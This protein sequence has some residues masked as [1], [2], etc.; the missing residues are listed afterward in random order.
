M[1]Y[2]LDTG[3]IIAYASYIEIVPNEEIPRWYF[4]SQCEKAHSFF[5]NNKTNILSSLVES[6]VD[7]VIN[8]RKS[9]VSI[10]MSK[11]QSKRVNPLHKKNL[12]PKDFDWI[13]E[14]FNIFRRRRWDPYI[15]SYS[16]GD[17]LAGLENRVDYLK[18]HLIKH[19]FGDPLDRQPRRQINFNRANSYDKDIICHSLQASRL[20]Q[21]NILTC[22]EGWTGITS[23]RLQ[24]PTI[25][26]LKNF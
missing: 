15:T 20:H 4:D 3:P 13:N 18:G 19:N 10:L 17:L 1:D 21:F 14:H 6:E 12:L 2:F 25:N 9:S 11:I 24:I 7:F 8:R 26:L 16:F 22:D 5:Q 23:Q